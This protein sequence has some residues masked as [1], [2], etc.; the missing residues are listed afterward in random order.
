MTEEQILKMKEGLKARAAKLYP[1]N[2]DRQNRYIFGTLNKIKESQ[3][4]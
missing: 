1:D 2:Q 3:K 4:K